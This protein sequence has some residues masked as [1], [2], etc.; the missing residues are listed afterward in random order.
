MGFPSPGTQP[1]NRGVGSKLKVASSPGSDCLLLSSSAAP[2]RG[3]PTCSP[4]RLHLLFFITQ[5]MTYLIDVFSPA[6]S[7]GQPSVRIKPATLFIFILPQLP[8]SVFF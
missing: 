3:S 7:R 8:S 1:N 2:Q 4:S 5:Q 6:G